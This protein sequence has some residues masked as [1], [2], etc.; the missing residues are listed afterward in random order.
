MLA[1]F[2][3]DSTVHIVQIDGIT[4]QGVLKHL[5]SSSNFHSGTVFHLRKIMR[6]EV[7]IHYELFFNVSLQ[8][9]SDPNHNG[10]YRY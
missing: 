10:S 6:F 5:H 4:V 8:H 7:L 1:H 9:I 3:L 2:F